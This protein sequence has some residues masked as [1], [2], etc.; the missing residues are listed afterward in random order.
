M[1]AG[2]SYIA[3]PS[4]CFPSRHIRFLCGSHL[5]FP[6]IRNK[7]A[8]IDAC[9]RRL[10]A[11]VCSGCPRALVKIFARFSMMVRQPR[12][13]SKAFCNPRSP[14]PNYFLCVIACYA[15]RA[16]EIRLLLGGQEK[17]VVFLTGSYNVHHGIA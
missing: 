17:I 1:G 3:S 9:C 14:T 4:V 6:R 2:Q 11:V 15:F 12:A 7:K 16:R 8:S 13:E 5:S 10:A